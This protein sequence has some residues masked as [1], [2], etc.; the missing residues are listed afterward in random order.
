MGSDEPWKDWEDI[1][2]SKEERQEP[3]QGL[4]DSIEKLREMEESHRTRVKDKK[5]T[6][7]DVLEHRKNV[8]SDVVS[9]LTEEIKEQ[10]SRLTSAESSPKDEE[11]IRDRL[12]ELYRERREE[13]RG[14]WRDRESW[15][16]V[17]MELE[18]ELAQI[19]E[20]EQLFTE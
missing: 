3:R 18:E 14:Y 17:E 11:V 10:K 5:E 16:E 12:Q 13:I 19:D 9:E 4:D 6:V 15:V 20:F 1:Q 2:D 8:Y 7:E